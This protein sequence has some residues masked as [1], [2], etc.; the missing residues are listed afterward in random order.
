MSLVCQRAGRR[1]EAE[2][3]LQQAMEKQWAA[4]RGQ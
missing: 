4:H 3:A 1:P 2:Q